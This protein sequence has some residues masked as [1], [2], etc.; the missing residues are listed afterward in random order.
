MRTVAGF[1]VVFFDTCWENACGL[2]CDQW[3]NV[4]KFTGE[5]INA[6]TVNFQVKIVCVKLVKLPG[7]I[8][9]TS[10]LFQS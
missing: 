10:Q 9:K 4:T 2:S 3:Q 6:A 8:A 7:W 1:W 5:H